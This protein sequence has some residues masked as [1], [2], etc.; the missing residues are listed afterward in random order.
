MS[1]R[2]HRVWLLPLLFLVGQAWALG[3][4]DIRLSSALNQPL[5]AEIQLLAATPEELNNLEVQ[6]ASAETFSRYDLD[7]PL[8]LTRLQFQVIKSGRADGNF[9][10]ITSADPVTE[11]FITFLV[12]ATWSRGRLLREYTMLLDPPTFAPAPTVQSTQAVTAPSRATP[13]DS[14]QIQRPAPQQAPQQAAPQTVRP[15]VQAP[16][17]TPPPAATQSEPVAAQ[18]QPT[19]VAP[20]APAPALVEE[21]ALDAQDF[22]ST[23]G[24]DLQVVRGDTLWGITAR[25]RPD[26]R[27]TF[28]QTMLAIY[29]ANPQ[30]FEGNI[31][32]LRAGASLK[33]PSA[34]DIFRINRGDA[35]AEVQRQ[36]EAWGG[37]PRSTDTATATT[38]TPDTFT[39]PNLTLVPPDDEDL[40]L[41]DTSTAAGP[42]DLVD[43]SA[44]DV[45]V[46][47]TEQRI[48]EIEALIEDQ[49]ALIEI[50]DNELAA[51]R[52][53]LAE[54]R[55]EEAPEPL[56][57][58]DGLGSDADDELAADEV[59]ADDTD[60]EPVDAAPPAVVSRPAQQEGI[61]DV[62]LGYLTNFWVIIG[63]A[64]LIAILVLVWFMRRA[65]GGDD[66]STGVWDS[67]DD[68]AMDPESLAGTESLRTISR[69]DETTILVE[70]QTRSELDDLMVD[71]LSASGTLELSSAD[72]E[73]QVFEPQPEPEAEQAV[74]ADPLA[75]TGATQ[76]LDDTFSSETAINLDQSD[77]VAEADFH[78]AYGLYDQAADLIN[79]ALTA[80]PQREDLLAKLCEIYFVWGNRDA[81]IDAST[82]LKSVV[83]SDTNVEWDKIVIMG[84]QIAGDHQMFSGVSAGAATKAVDL[85]FEGGDDDTGA[86]DMDLDG[87]PDDDNEVI[88]LGAETGQVL[89]SPESGSDIDFSFEEADPTEASA[90]R[91][92]HEATP[93]EPIIDSVA[94][95]GA[96]ATSDNDDAPDTDEAVSSPTIEQQFD[97][98]EATGELPS[99]SEFETPIP[100]ADAT[101]EIDLDDLGLDLDSLTDVS[102]AED[103][104]GLDDTAESQALNLDDLDAT[105]INVAADDDLEATGQNPA[106]D[107]TGI[108]EGVN[109]ADAMAGDDATMLATDETGII[110]ALED[111]GE[112]TD[113]GL[114]TSLLDATGMTQVISEDMA[115]D[116]GTDIGATLSDDDKTMLAPSLGDAAG[117]EEAETMLAPLDDDSD[118]GD[119]DFARTEALPKDVFSSDS[120]ADD[121]GRMKGLTG[122][123][124]MDLDLDDLTAALKVSEVGD[125]INQARDDK[126][127]EQ[128]RVD[129][130]AIENIDLDVGGTVDENESNTTQALAPDD[131]SEDLHD[132]R[133][134][135]EVGTK[136]DLAR[137][138]VD[139]GDPGGA[140]SILEE[141]LDEGDNA[142]KQ[143]AQQLLDSLP[144]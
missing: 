16:V 57:V 45:F 118:D 110:P 143:Q 141:V 39:E 22:N 102:L 4:G 104:A 25:V 59:Q 40:A 73:S 81:F 128:R 53:E 14:G 79:G 32:R 61:V 144:A 9:V 43:D 109:I 123:T 24:G 52:A 76:A 138:Y 65:G 12:E 135:T 51:L 100:S 117:P 67:L 84:Q 129:P 23:S 96:A 105:G 13:S 126:T 31:N 58:D 87:E 95:D 113:I 114:D 10:R 50:P 71:D 93:Q 142:Q 101:A 91:E 28:N 36:N 69:D 77:P 30:A 97:V 49:D 66:D 140:R 86:L 7:R 127:V 42:D 54:L 90:T 74:A 11:P 106:L 33:I 111:G 48:N 139:M 78:M 38:T 64:L 17:Q 1:R 2:L 47:P 121:T 132:A 103:V 27:L 115:V 26:S 41:T 94:D 85:S 44:D 130:A 8:Y 72:V 21:P 99:L 80:E 70:E 5:R 18:T 98:L 35:F 92:M 60:A 56:P 89:I 29:E 68:S 108:L 82:R 19:P 3:L 20:P 137:A 116:T 133:T 125:T 15:P 134:M 107:Q 120:S 124:D 136:L 75:E 62:I 131:I 112:D 119:F 122:S 46:D 37:L 55:G 6:L 63:V 88:D 83:G 34:D